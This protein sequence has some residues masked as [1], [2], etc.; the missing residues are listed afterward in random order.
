MGGIDRFGKRFPEIGILVFALASQIPFLLNDGTFWDGLLM[1][2][3]LETD[4]EGAMS[5][6]REVGLPIQAAEHWLISLF[7]SP[8]LVFK[9]LNIGGLALMGWSVY[10]LSGRAFGLAPAEAWFI[11]ALSISFPIYHLFVSSSLHQY[12]FGMALF[13]F[14]WD[15]FYRDYSKQ[16]GPIRTLVALLVIFLGFSFNA[17][18]VLHY[19]LAALWLVQRYAA[20]SAANSRP[21]LRAF[22]S[23]VVLRN[24]PILGLPVVYWI[25]RQLIWKPISAVEQDYNDPLVW[26]GKPVS[27]LVVL[28]DMMWNALVGAIPNVF[29]IPYLSIVQAPI[30]VL[31]SGLAAFAI[32]ARLVH[33]PGD[34]PTGSWRHSLSLVWWGGLLLFLAVLPFVAVGKISSAI[35][36]WRFAF[37]AGFPFSVLMLGLSRM[38]FHLVLRLSARRWSL[39]V[40]GALVGICTAANGVYGI[41]WAARW[42][43]EKAVIQKLAE[44]DPPREVTV[45]SVEDRFVT[46][47]PSAYGFWEYAV[48]FSMAWQDGVKRTAFRTPYFDHILSPSR[49]PGI[50]GINKTY[51]RQLTSPEAIKYGLRGYQLSRCF[52]TITIDRGPLVLS[53]LGLGLR[54]LALSLFDAPGLG[55]LFRQIVEVRMSPAY[56]LLFRYAPCREGGPMNLSNIREFNNRIVISAFPG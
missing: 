29:F 48:H 11:A 7:P 30:I 56:D 38:G 52:A 32:T 6:L 5:W 39:A 14:G 31:G 41:A 28:G 23:S 10:G 26:L 33:G 46:M 40:L 44:L 34:Q 54:Y 49:V 42:A 12:M 21:A 13:F 50:I 9:I 4:V 43:K 24:L 8:R 27:G 51:F 22:F 25:L 47:V 2:Y 37:L 55:G 19:G 53:D 17:T 15:L 36:D 1:E 45:F 35:W 3:L 20:Q 18:L 16:I